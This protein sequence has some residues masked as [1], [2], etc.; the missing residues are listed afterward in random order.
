MTQ[1]IKVGAVSYLNTKPLIYG[2]EKGMM[3]AETELVFDFPANIA[4]KLLNNEIDIGL[5]P[6]AVLPL[7]KEYHIVA[8]YGIG[9]D[10][11]VESVCLFSDVPLAEIKTVLLDYQSRTSVALLKV[12]LKEHWKITPEL[13]AA[14]KGFEQQ[15]KGSTAGLVIG[16][17]A[18]KQIP[19]STYHYDLGLAWKEMTGLPFLFAAWVSNKK[20]T[21][22]FTVAFNKATSFG[23]D[24]I[25][26][27]VKAIDYKE[28]DLDDY[29]KNKIS[30]LLDHKKRTALELFLSKLG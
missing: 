25:D 1:K 29:Y 10:G 23:L 14:E 28:A 11:A 4:Q 18:F 16:D 9:C 22:E 12:L 3:H 15:I 27:I 24:Y 26:S 20:M 5:I 21:P 19:V 7:M 13:I 2:F 8:D 6:V 30:F 17:R